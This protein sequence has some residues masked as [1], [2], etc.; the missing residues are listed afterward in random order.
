MSYDI[1]VFVADANL[2]RSSDF[3]KWYEVQAAQVDDK[4]Y[5]DGSIA[6]ISLQRWFEEMRLL[7]PPMNG[8]HTIDISTID[9]STLADYEIRE[10]LIYAAFAWSQADLAFQYCF[11]LAEKCALG[12]FNVSSD[13][14]EIWVPNKQS[15]LVLLS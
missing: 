2:K 4:F 15:K 1:V 13:K 6:N 12:M 8:S 14:A 9:E 3:I 10:L 5:D 11:Q 7:F